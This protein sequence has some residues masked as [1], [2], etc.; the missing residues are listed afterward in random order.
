MKMCP[1]RWAWPTTVKSRAARFAAIPPGRLKIIF[2]RETRKILGVHII[3][4]G[5]QRIAAHRAGGY[6]PQRHDRLFRR[7]GFQLS[8]AGRS[9]KAA[10]FNGINKVSKYD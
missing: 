10:A 4:E 1:M 2:H 9:Y 6:D 8:D 3:G 7:Y 5:R